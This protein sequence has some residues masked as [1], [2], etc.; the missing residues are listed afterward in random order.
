MSVA[1]RYSTADW[2]AMIGVAE[3]AVGRHLFFVSIFMFSSV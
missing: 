2:F 1:I 3:F